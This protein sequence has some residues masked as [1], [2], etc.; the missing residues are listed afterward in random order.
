MHLLENLHW[1]RTKTYQSKPI[2]DQND[3]K[4]NPL[5]LLCLFNELHW[6]STKV[7]QN[8]LSE[9]ENGKKPESIVTNSLIKETTLEEDQNILE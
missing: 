8:K 1:L 4:F 7:D 6:L 5:R 2:E 9:E 3:K